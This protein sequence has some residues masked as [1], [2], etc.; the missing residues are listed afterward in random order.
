MAY[1]LPVGGN[2]VQQNILTNIPDCLEALRKN[3]AKYIAGGGV[4]GLDDLKFLRD[5]G[6]A[7]ALVGSALHDGQVSSGD[8]RREGLAGAVD[9][10][11]G[12]RSGRSCLTTLAMA[13][14]VLSWMAWMR[15]P[16]S[17]RMS[18]RRYSFSIHSARQ[19]WSFFCSAIRSVKGSGYSPMPSTA[20][21]SSDST[22]NSRAP[23]S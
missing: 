21:A 19:A 14:P 4:A 15:P 11:G 8:L 17:G 5:A 1:N 2:Q 6:F 3:D 22:R 7:G 12:L 13:R 23:M 20:S 18:T 9:G 16:I 10:D